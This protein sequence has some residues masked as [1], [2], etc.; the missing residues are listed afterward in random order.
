[1][2]CGYQ[3]VHFMAAQRTQQQ[4]RHITTR[5]ESRLA[6]SLVLNVTQ[7]LFCDLN[8]TQHRHHQLFCSIAIRMLIA[9]LLYPYIN[10][11]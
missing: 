11:E 5:Y 10:L 9:P 6:K 4:P 2:H 8:A 3:Y 7:N 1:M